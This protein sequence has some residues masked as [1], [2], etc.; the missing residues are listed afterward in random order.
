M[1][2]TIQHLAD[3]LDAH[4]PVNNTAKFE[5]LLGVRECAWAIICA[6]LRL[7]EDHACADVRAIR[8]LQGNVAGEMTTFTGDGSPV[9]WIVRS[10]IGKPETGFTN[11]HLTCWLDPSVDVPHLG[12][13]LGTAPDVFCYCDFLP[14]VEACTDYGY[15][16]RYLEPMNEAWIALRRNPRYKT[17]NPV[18]LYTRS[19]LSPIAICGLLPFDDFCEVVEPV[20]MDYVRA[21]VKLV[22][23]AQ[24]TAEAHRPA[25]AQRDHVLR[26]TIVEKDPANVLADRMLGAPMRERLVRILWGAEREQ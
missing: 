15:C 23:E 14:R 9:D 25:I 1:S 4:R 3:V 11:I 26:K 16:E 10:W 21:W 7:R 13:A 8:D 6:G 12:F 24:P 18:H 19:T 20:M 17:F 2:D 22:Q 5:Y